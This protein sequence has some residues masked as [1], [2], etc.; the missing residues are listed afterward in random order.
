MDF[1]VRIYDG[2]RFYLYEDSIRYV[3]VA[4]LFEPNS[5]SKDDI[6]C[7]DWHK[8]EAHKL[9][10]LVLEKPERRAFIERFR[11]YPKIVWSVEDDY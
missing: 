11:K 2:P 9:E 6:N 3:A 8:V 10:L 5:I 1:K 7:I 4:D